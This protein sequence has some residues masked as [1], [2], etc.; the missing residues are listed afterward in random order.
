[1]AVDAHEITDGDN[2]FL[3][4]LGQLACR[5][6]NQCLTCLEVGVGLLED[7]GRW[8]VQEES[9]GGCVDSKLE[10]DEENEEL[11]ILRMNGDRV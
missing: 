4:L 8:K 9:E 11:V 7:L 10:V 1:M 3:N 5:C 6:K 2:T